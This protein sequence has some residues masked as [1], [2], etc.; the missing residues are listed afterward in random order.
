MQPA[1]S[2]L[3][4]RGI[5]AFD[6]VAFFMLDKYAGE[7]PNHVGTVQ[8]NV[9]FLKRHTFVQCASKVVNPDPILPA[10]VLFL[11]ILLLLASKEQA[12]CGIVSKTTTN[13]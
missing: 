13:F 5:D 4:L 1:H 2:S 7:Q 10:H 8:N 3:N 12:L 9:R 11:S 6:I